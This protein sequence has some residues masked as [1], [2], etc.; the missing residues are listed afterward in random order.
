M[1]QKKQIGKNLKLEEQRL[2][3]KVSVF[4]SLVTVHVF[5]ICQISRLNIVF[6]LA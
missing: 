3:I 5:L 1:K 6:V 2:F 4:S